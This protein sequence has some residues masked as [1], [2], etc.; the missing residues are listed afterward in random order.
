MIPV[1]VQ[2]AQDAEVQRVAG[3]ATVQTAK[4]KKKDREAVSE[5]VTGAHEAARAGMGLPPA[6]EPEDDAGARKAYDAVGIH[7]GPGEPV[8][9][10]HVAPGQFGR[11][12]IGDGHAAP[13]PGHDPPNA[14]PAEAPTQ[15][16]P[17]HV[18]L[19]NSRALVAEIRPHTGGDQCL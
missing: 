11:P 8:M 17:A 4:R 14:M 16:R 10:G 1:T 2:G 3:L 6:D 5:M 13:S 15:P 7:Q 9:P 12:Y 18:D 19:T